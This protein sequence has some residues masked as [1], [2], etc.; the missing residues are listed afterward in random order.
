MPLKTIRPT[1]PNGGILGGILGGQQFKSLRN[2]VKRLGNKLCTY[3]MQVNLGMDTG[4]TNWP[5]ETSGGA[6]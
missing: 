2:V 6:F 1:I 4:S 3:V 5:H